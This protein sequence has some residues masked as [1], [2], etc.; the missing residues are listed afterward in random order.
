MLVCLP[1]PDTPTLTRR[2]PLSVA[3]ENSSSR[4]RRFGPVRVNLLRR[5]LPTR[6][7]QADRKSTRLNSSHRTISYAVFCLKNKFDL[8]S[9]FFS[10]HLVLTSVPQASSAPVFPTHIATS[11]TLYF[12][13]LTVNAG[14]CGV[15]HCIQMYTS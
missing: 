7:R 15:L 10:H 6:S 12:D 3:T 5:D 11:S 8:N 2:K 13:S 1:D 4:I 9:F 14:I